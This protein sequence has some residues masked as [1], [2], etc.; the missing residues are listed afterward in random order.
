MNIVIFM[1]IDYILIVPDALDVGFDCEELNILNKEVMS[2]SGFIFSYPK[3][4]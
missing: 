4:V 3:K 2:R 1:I